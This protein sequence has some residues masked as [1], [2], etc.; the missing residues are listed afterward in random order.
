MSKRKVLFALGFVTL[1]SVSLL[2][3]SFLLPIALSC[4]EKIGLASVSKSNLLSVH[5]NGITKFRLPS[6]KFPNGIF[7]AS[8]GSV[9]FGEQDVPGI[10]HLYPNGTMVEYAWP[11]SYYPSTTSIWGIAQWNGRVWGS[12]A[13][14][15]Q[16]VGLDSSTAA[17]YAVKLSERGAFPYTVTVGPDDAL[18][19]TELFVSKVGRIDAQCRL[20]EFDVPSSFGGTPTQIGFDNTTSGYYVDA[21]NTTGG[22]GTVLSFDPREFA[23]Q[24]IYGTFNLR[25]PSS[26]ALVGGGIFVA[27]HTS[28]TL[29]FHDSNAHEWVF[30]PTSPVNYF[31][32][33]LPYFVAANG[34]MVWFNE[35]YANRMA[36]LD[37][38]RGLLTEYSLSDPPANRITGID[39]ALTFAL[40]K[41]RVW[42]TE[43]TANYVG[44]V[45][46]SY[47]PTFIVSQAS[48]SKLKLRPGASVNVTFVVSGESTKPLKVQFADTENVTGRPRRIMMNANATEIQSLN[49]QKDILVSV[50]ADKTLPL[51]NYMLL[52]TVTDGSTSQGVYLKLQVS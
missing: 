24:P 40:G 52:V 15:S 38:D 37:A 42:F 26:L 43:L 45:D 44:Y 11:V 13:L 33:T 1:L 29:A 27:Q 17:L 46:A 21:G 19:F 28:S 20:K 25:A 7:R 12:D 35:H 49:G 6:G 23:P 14:G 47:Q 5:F 39:N 18:W 9:W 22:L 31:D 41:D 16:I 36:R 32:T 50:T 34:S 30:F 2:Y 8:D 4:G 10:A 3:L 48:N 51:G